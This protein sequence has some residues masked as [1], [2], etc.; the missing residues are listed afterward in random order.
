MT[1]TQK[2]IVNQVIKT[3]QEMA[4]EKRER[5]MTAKIVAFGKNAGNM[6]YKDFPAFYSVAI[7]DE[8]IEQ[9]KSADQA[10]NIIEKFV[11][12]EITQRE[13]EKI[14]HAE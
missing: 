9:V 12:N 11:K 1:E 4:K 8:I 7:I 10:A 5:E 3:A 13:I 14:I 2:Q 6:Y